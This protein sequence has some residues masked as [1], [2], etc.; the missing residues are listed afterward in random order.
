M[1][2]FAGFETIDAFK[3]YPSKT[4]IEKRS[5]KVSRKILKDYPT[6]RKISKTQPLMIIKV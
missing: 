5:I 6:L 1:S 3:D 4:E 2:L